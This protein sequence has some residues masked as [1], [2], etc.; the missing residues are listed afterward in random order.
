[1]L[2]PTW[3]GCSSPHKVELGMSKWSDEAIVTEVNDIAAAPMVCV[4]HA[5]GHGDEAGS[6]ATAVGAIAAAACS[7]TSRRC[8]STDSG[9]FKLT[10]T[11]DIQR[12]S[13]RR[14]D[15]TQQGSL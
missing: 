14:A 5:M 13:R 4:M 12:T 6:T 2:F 3:P 10:R 9:Y 11:Q 1:L 7:T 15:R 8:R